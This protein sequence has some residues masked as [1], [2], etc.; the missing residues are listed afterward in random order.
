MV[1]EDTKF[2]VLQTGQGRFQINR[3]NRLSFFIFRFTCQLVGGVG[4]KFAML[5]F[6]TSQTF[7]VDVIDIKTI[8]LDGDFDR[9]VRLAILGPV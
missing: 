4:D 5:R 2:I 1:R 8:E 7:D 3:E 6:R 9:Q